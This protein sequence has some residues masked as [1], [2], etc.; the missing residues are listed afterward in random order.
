MKIRQNI[1]LDSE[2]D[3]DILAWLEAQENKSEAVRD[4][5]RAFMDRDRVTLDSVYE[6]VSRIEGKLERGVAQIGDGTGTGEVAEDPE[7][8]EALANLGI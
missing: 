7:L 2:R 1:S 8:V 4:A 5:I 3:A 6:A